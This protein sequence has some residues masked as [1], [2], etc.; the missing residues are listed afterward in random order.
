MM[1]N[2]RPRTRETG[3]KKGQHLLGEGKHSREQS[4]GCAEAPRNPEVFRSGR[5]GYYFERHLRGKGNVF[6]SQIKIKT[7]KN[8][9]GMLVLERKGTKKDSSAKTVGHIPDRRPGKERPYERRKKKGPNP[10]P[11]RKG[12]NERRR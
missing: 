10:I 2:G 3:K 11:L 6:S 8:T 5:S 1:G 9:T 7:L 12:G 4:L